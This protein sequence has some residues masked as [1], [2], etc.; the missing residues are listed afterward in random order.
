MNAEFKQVETAQTKF[1]QEPDLTKHPYQTTVR[2][3][4]KNQELCKSLKEFSLSWAN[5]SQRPD[6]FPKL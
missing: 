1:H 3:M 5:K 6:N 2:P 4:L